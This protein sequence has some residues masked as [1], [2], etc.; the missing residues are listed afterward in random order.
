MADPE[1][2]KDQP[3]IAQLHLVFGIAGLSSE[4][5]D[6][7]QVTSCEDQWRRSLD[8]IVT[9][10]TLST[11]QCLILAM[12][13]CISKADYNRLQHY[14]GIAV[15]LSH[16]L[17]LHQSQKRFSFGALTIETRKKVFWTLYTIDW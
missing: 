5:P 12:M 1:Q 15:G 7:Q 16:R 10:N 3:K 4:I 13:H 14:K 17:G 9:D 6:K 8:A 2:I 11:L